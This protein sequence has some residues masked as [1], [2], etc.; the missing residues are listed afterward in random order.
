M[1]LERRQVQQ[2]GC[3]LVEETPPD[4][5]AMLSPREKDAPTLAPGREAVLDGLNAKPF[6]NGEKVRL[7]DFNSDTGRWS[8]ECGRSYEDMPSILN[9]KPHNLRCST[10]F[11]MLYDAF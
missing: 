10:R 8:V 9:V 5:P 2:G 11:D 6:L 7:L 4:A 3:I 1:R